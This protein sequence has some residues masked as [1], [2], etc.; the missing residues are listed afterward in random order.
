MTGTPYLLATLIV[1]MV[2]AIVLHEIAH[3]F[4]F[5]EDEITLQGVKDGHILGTIVQQPFEFGYQSV[6]LMADLAGQR[7]AQRRQRSAPADG[8]GRVGAEHLPGGGVDHQRG[9]GARLSGRQRACKAH[10]NAD[11]ADAMPLPAELMATFP[12]TG[13]APLSRS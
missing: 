11:G 7:V 10:Q 8:G 3:Y 2:F 4:G 6:R 9:S 13:A 1:P 5:D 12:V